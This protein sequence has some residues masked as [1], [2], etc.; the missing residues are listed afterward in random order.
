MQFESG[1]GRD[2]N[3]YKVKAVVGTCR[4]GNKVCREGQME[5]PGSIS[6][7]APVVHGPAVW[8]SIDAPLNCYGWVSVP[9]NQNNLD[10]Y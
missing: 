3:S 2:Q 8:E 4:D 10:I 9:G 5:S 6:T 1:A 7:T